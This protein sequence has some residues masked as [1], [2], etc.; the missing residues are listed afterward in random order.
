MSESEGKMILCFKYL[1]R[2]AGKLDRSDLCDEATLRFLK[3]KTEQFVRQISNIFVEVYQEV[4][5]KETQL[6]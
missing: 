5:Q 1:D 4:H 6:L 2:I 3:Q